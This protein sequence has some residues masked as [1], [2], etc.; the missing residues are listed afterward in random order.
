MTNMRALA[1][2]LPALAAAGPAAALDGAALFAQHCAAC[3][4]ADGSGTVGLAPPLKGEHW[5]RLGADRSYLPTVLVHGLSGAI[6]LGGQTFVGSM[7]AFGPQLDDA[8]LAAMATHVRQ[9]QGATGDKPYDSA[10]IQ[11]ARAQAGSPP[12]T[13]QKRALI[14]GS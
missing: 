12:Q 3:H 6:K 7:P 9:L 14:L 2:L 8:A 4:Q 13:R 11:A 10:D 1:A 5:A